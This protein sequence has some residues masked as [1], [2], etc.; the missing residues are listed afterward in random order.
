M[1]AILY[2]VR[3]LFNVGSI[4]RTSDAVGI[5]KIYLCGIT[6]TPFDVFGKKRPQLA[7]VSLGA[8]DSVKWEKIVSTTKLIAK[9]KSAGYKIVAIEQAENSVA[10]YNFKVGQNKIAL[11]V[12]HEVKGLPKNILALADVVVEIPMAGTKESLNVGV[13]FGVVAFRLTEGVITN[14]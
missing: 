3:S 8:E 13:A 5:E 9:L 1:I 11:V 6:P 7:K 4:F 10:Y 12:G 2:N 14:P